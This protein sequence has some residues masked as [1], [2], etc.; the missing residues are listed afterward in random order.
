MPQEEKTDF[1]RRA[2]LSSRNDAIIKS[3]NTIELVEEEWELIE[4]DE[5]GEETEG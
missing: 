2:S 4:K 1:S 3:K 5:V